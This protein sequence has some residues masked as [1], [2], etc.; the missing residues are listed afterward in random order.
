MLIE[1]LAWLY[2]STH[3]ISVQST[4]VTQLC[5]TLCEPKN[6]STPGFPVHHQLPEF[7]QTHVQWCHPTIS[8]ST[9]LLLSSIFPR[10]RLFSNKLTLRIRW[11]K[12]WNFNISLTNEYSGLFSFRICWFYFL[13]CS[14]LCLLVNS[15][16][17]AGDLDSIPASERS[18]GEGNGNPLQC[19]YQENSMDRR[20]WWATVYGVAKSWT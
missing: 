8:S 17:K 12:Y 9:T 16:C 20:A 13:W 5:P 11:P 15:A 6:C 10:I 18:L 4:S 1:L 7:T 2:L 14:F 3:Y 19:S